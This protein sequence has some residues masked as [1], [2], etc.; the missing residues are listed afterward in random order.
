MV[1]RAVNE[2]YI[3]DRHGRIGEVW[4]RFFQADFVRLGENFPTKI[5]NRADFF[6]QIFSSR[7]SR[8]GENFPTKIFNRADFSGWAKMRV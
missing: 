5:F 8:L 2:F 6:E 4:S 3:R 1:R 7:F